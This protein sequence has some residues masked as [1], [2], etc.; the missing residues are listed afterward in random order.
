MP[1]AKEQLTRLIEQQPDDSSYEELV[2]ELALALMV[3][4]G[5]HDSDEGRTISSREMHQRIR[6]WSK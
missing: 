3:E 6:A 1:S 2:R 5:L 4:R